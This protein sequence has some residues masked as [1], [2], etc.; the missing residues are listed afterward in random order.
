MSPSPICFHC[1]IPDSAIIS[2]RHEEHRSAHAMV[3][4]LLLAVLL[5][6]PLWT[7][8]VCS[9]DTS[10]VKIH[11]PT[12]TA[13]PGGSLTV[14]VLITRAN[15]LAGLK[16]VL[17]YD[18]SS[19]KFDKLIKGKKA[20]GLMHVVNSK[21]PGRLIV[22]MAGARGVSGN[23]FPLF[24]MKFTAADF[25]AGSSEIKIQRVELMGEDLKAITA[26]SGNGRIRFSA[27]EAKAADTPAPP[28]PGKPDIPAAPTPPVPEKPENPVADGV[29]Q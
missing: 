20:G 7:T 29:H 25:A 21:T 4:A 17:H 10:G 9:A 11:I 1:L 16:L 2:R 27:P 8:P 19:L 6:I 26:K 13:S 3:L 24:E 12:L 5:W 14:P 15:K 28:A 22:V 23:E 18:K